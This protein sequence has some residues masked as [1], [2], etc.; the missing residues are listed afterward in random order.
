MVLMAETPTPTPEPTYKSAPATEV[1]EEPVLPMG[2]PLSGTTLTGPELD[3]GAADA[4]PP[5]EPSWWTSSPWRLPQ[6]IFGSVLLISGLGL[7]LLRR[8]SML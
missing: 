8:R 2:E 4:V 3:M 5:P 1:V 6:V 7:I